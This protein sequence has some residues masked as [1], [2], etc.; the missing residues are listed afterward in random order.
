MWVRLCLL[1]SQVILRAL[2]ISCIT[3]VKSHEGQIGYEFFQWG[4]VGYRFIEPIRVILEQIATS[5]IIFGINPKIY[6]VQF[7][8][9][10]WWDLKTLP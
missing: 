4:G 8:C 6:W 10:S 1:A 3:G 5:I 7:Y 9:M 2:K